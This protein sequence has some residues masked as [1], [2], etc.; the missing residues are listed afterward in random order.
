[1]R[2][3]SS[4]RLGEEVNH[5]GRVGRFHT[6]R[7]QMAS[8]CRRVRSM[9]NR[10][11][12]QGG[13][14][15]RLLEEHSRRTT[16]MLHKHPG[17]TGFRMWHEAAA[18]MDVFDDTAGGL[19]RERALNYLVIMT[20]PPGDSTREVVTSPCTLCNNQLPP[21]TLVGTH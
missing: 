4:P 18:I 2:P 15:M 12:D 11:V 20:L 7:L 1:M 19:L 5:I 6:L 13:S 3:Q 9:C 10:L 8:A 17:T 21:I 14:R 16:C